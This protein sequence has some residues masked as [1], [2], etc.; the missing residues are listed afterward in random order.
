MLPLL[1]AATP[2]PSPTSGVDANLVTPGVVGFL[3]TLG[4]IVATILLLVSLTRRIR[5]VNN[6]ALIAERL[7]A[8]EAAAAEKDDEKQ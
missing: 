7:D 3:V 5:R 8:E 4:L 6:R 1:W 2:T